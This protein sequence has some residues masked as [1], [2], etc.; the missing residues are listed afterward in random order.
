MNDQSRS[1]RKCFF[2]YNPFLRTFIIAIPLSIQCV[3]MREKGI[4]ESILCVNPAT[5]ILTSLIVLLYVVC[6]YDRRCNEKLS[7]TLLRP[8]LY[9][10][11]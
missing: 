1:K 8:L 10:Q 11:Q 4:F 3:R 2:I 9:A 6:C 5:Q 7:L